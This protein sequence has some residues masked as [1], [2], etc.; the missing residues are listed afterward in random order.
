[1]DEHVT[2]IQRYVIGD[3]EAK[4]TLRV[5]PLAYPTEDLGVG[6]PLEGWG[7]DMGITIAGHGAT[8]EE[9]SHQTG[10]A[11]A[12][13]P[14]VIERGVLEPNRWELVAVDVVGVHA[15]DAVFGAD[16]HH[17]SILVTSAL[18]ALALVWI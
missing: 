3:D 18:R 10:L 12:G 16:A 14:D 7:V 15:F 8:S 6:V 11:G 13:A 5:V 17:V 2:E 9:A 4:S 1:M